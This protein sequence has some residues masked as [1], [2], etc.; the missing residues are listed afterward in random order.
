MKNIL[1]SGATGLIGGQLIEQLQKKHY[2]IS[3]LSRNEQNIP[4]VKC[5]VWDVRQQILPLEAIE[6]ADCIVHLAGA[7]IGSKRWTEKRK[8]EIIDSRVDS[9]ALLLQRIKEAQHKPQAFITASAVGYYGLHTSDKIYTEDDAPADDFFGE[10]GASWENVL[11]GTEAMG[12]RSV[13]LRLGIVLAKEEGA[14]PK[15]AMPLKFGFGSP[16]GSG[17]QYIPWIHID[18]AVSLFMKAIE[19]TSLKGAYNAAA[20]EHITNAG[21]T[22]LLCQVRHRLFIPIGVPAFLLKLVLGEMADIV[23]KGSR[24]SSKKIIAT[25]FEF[26]HPGLRKALISLS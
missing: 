24:V 13:A 17:K 3:I 22:K 11:T 8:K 18:D 10:V 26:Q 21:F 15:M 9:G 19:D 23:L 1:I 16:I 2:Q 25:G 12:L 14:L 20:P 5:Y 4:K 7:N 6:Q